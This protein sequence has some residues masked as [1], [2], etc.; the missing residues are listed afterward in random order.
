MELEH[1]APNG[2]WQLLETIFHDALKIPTPSRRQYLENVCG[3]DQTLLLEVISLLKYD[4]GAESDLH[5]VVAHELN[6]LDKPARSSE[7]GKQIG[8]YRLVRELDG[9]G[10]GVVHLAVRS[11]DHYFQVI[12]IKM[13]REGFA[14]P[15]VIQRFRNERQ[16][17]AT[18]AHPNIGVILDGGETDDGCPF[19]AMEYVEGL[20]ITVACTSRN[21]RIRQR[22]ELFRSVCSA[23]HYA[24]QKLI[25]HRDIKPDNVLVTPEGTVKLIDFGIAK[26]VVPESLMYEHSP[27]ESSF[28]LM[29]PD[30]ASPEQLLGKQLTTASD[31]YSLG[32]LLLSCSR[33]SVHIT[34]VAVRQQTQNGQYWRKSDLIRVLLLGF[35]NKQK[36]SS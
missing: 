10:M 3:G 30:Y 19:I 26:P 28:R 6:E 17:L 8:P 34:Y 1:Q 13:I 27:T 7:V 2:R 35:Q 36:K 33:V 25:I 15:V 23:V 14:S 21:L 24:H 18:L 29:T 11:D 5:E 20:P 32:V 12:A 22:V 9:G 4:D 31:I 16:I